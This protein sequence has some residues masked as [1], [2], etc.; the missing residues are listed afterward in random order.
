MSVYSKL[1]WFSFKVE[2][3]GVLVH[4]LSTKKG[5]LQIDGLVLAWDCVIQSPFKSANQ[6]KSLEQETILRKGL[7]TLQV[8]DQ[9]AFF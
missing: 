4:L 8:S 6:T 2:R 7:F 3:L 9:F 1:Y 5:L